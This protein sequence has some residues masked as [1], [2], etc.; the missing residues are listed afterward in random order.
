VTA[1]D[2]PSV[3]GFHPDWLALVAVSF[4]SNVIYAAL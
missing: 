1:H 4:P 2:W 3:A